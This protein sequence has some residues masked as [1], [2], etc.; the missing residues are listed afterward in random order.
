MILIGGDF[1]SP[2]RQFS[3]GDVFSA[4][5]DPM[6]AKY[7]WP[8][9]NT[10]L[11]DVL[12]IFGMGAFDYVYFKNYQN[13]TIESDICKTEACTGYSDHFPVVF[14]ISLNNQST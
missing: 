9:R 6:M 1:N 12:N 11:G 10:C 14:Y 4:Y 13:Y 2:L 8:H 7:P 5:F 3:K